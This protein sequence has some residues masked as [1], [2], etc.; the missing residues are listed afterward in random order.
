MTPTFGHTNVIKYDGRPFK[1]AKE[2]DDT[3]IANWNSVV[4]DGDTVYHLGDFAFAEVKRVEEILRCLNGNKVFIFG[5]HDR[6]MH[7]AAIKK[8][9]SFMTTYY[10]L[11]Q[12]GEMI[13]LFHYPVRRMEQRTSWCISCSWSLSW[14]LCLS[15]TW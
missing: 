12:D 10:E 11:K 4:K 15:E 13:V 6:V 9:F 5:N 2:M 1:T 3:I 7:D 8:H 14:Q